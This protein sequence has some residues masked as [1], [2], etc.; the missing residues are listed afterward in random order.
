MSD[1]LETIEEVKEVI[2]KPYTLRELEDED[3]Y[4]VLEIVGIVLPDE[5][6]ASFAQVAGS[7]KKLEEVGGMVAFDLLRYVMK[8]FKAVKTEVYNFL[9]DLSGIPADDIKK[10]PFGTTP[11]M[12]KE[13]FLNEKNSSFFMEFSK[14]FS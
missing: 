11:K 3:L 12:L 6:K 10:M 13:V 2:E 1:N 9:S 7:G 8:N 14:L 5:A 4:T